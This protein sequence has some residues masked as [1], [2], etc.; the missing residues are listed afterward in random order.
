METIGPLTADQAAE[1]VVQA[2]V[3]IDDEIASK[4][5]GLVGGGAAEASVA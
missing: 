3:K 1:V 4:I 5:K 2:G